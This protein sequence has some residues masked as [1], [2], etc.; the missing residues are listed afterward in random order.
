MRQKLHQVR[1]VTNCKKIKE[2]LKPEVEIF[3][4]S[5]RFDSPAF[6]RNR[7]NPIVVESTKTFHESQDAHPVCMQEAFAERYLRFSTGSSLTLAGEFTGMCVQRIA[8]AKP[9]MP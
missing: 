5:L 3:F 9:C 6:L 2:N 7:I 8:L 1:Q 4:L